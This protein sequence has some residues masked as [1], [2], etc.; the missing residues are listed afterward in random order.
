LADDDGVAEED[1]GF[2]S[3]ELLGIEIGDEVPLAF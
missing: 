2:L 1:V 3:G